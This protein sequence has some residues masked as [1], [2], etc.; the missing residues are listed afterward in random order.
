MNF[1]KNTRNFL[2]CSFCRKIWKNNCKSR[3]NIGGEVYYSG[4]SVRTKICPKDFFRNN[5]SKK[6]LND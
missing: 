4:Q 2:R 5:N 3:F 6:K 1:L